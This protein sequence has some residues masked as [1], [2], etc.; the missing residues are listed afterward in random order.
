[1]LHGQAILWRER[2]KIYEI[3][4]IMRNIFPDR[5]GRRICNEKGGVN[6]YGW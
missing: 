1:M 4:G 2:Y 3:I 5:Y 6:V